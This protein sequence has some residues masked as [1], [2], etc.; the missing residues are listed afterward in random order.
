V[1]TTRYRVAV[2]GVAH[3]H[4][5]ELMRRFAQ[6]PNVEMVAIADTGPPELNQTSPSTRAHTLAVARSE[7]GIQRSYG[8]YRELLERE[9]PDI[10][11]LCPELA[12]T[13][14]IGELVARSGAHILTE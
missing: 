1:S 6:L 12:R 11:L 2:V 8:D 5:N 10:V 3:M 4:V 14:E 9:Q 7:I 13:G